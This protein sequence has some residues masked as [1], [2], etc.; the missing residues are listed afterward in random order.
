[1]RL[2]GHA[3]PRGEPEY[4]MVLGGKRADNV[5]GFIIEKGLPEPQVST[6]SRGEDEAKG[7]DEATW[8]ADRRVDV[9]L[10]D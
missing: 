4:N 10:A 9:V 8:A 1:M 6:T 3:D 5:K 7:T 2:V